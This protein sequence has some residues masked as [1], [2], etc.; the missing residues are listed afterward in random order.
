MPKVVT[1]YDVYPALDIGFGSRHWQVSTYADF[2]RRADRILFVSQHS[3][4]DFLRLFPYDVSRTSVTHLGVADSF[5]PRAP[6]TLAPTREKYGLAE[7]YLLFVG[8]SNPQKNLLRLLDAFGR[9]AARHDHQ[10]MLA[11]PVYPGQLAPMQ[12]RVAQLAIEARVRIAGFVDAADLPN[13]YAGASAVLLPSVYEGFGLPILEG[14]AS[15]VPVLTSTAGSCPEI[16][17]G[18]GVLVDPLS[19]DD[20]ARGIDAAL[21][22]TKTQLEDARTYARGM[23]WRRTA[24]QTLET[25]RALC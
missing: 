17:A 9:S 25:Y 8:A 1:C 24:Q 21:R 7:P 11:G 18:H 5:H 19:V 20:I 22:M 14:M 13:L 3:R 6:E 2:A 10:L 4:R 12:A 15:G 23:T 16:A